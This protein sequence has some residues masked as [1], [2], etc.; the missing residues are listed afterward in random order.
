MVSKLPIIWKQTVKEQTIVVVV[1][2]V[3]VV[4]VVVVVFELAQMTLCAMSVGCLWFTD[5]TARHCAAR[6]HPSEPSQHV[7]SSSSQLG[8]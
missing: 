8:Y 2:V 5:T 7:A 1:V 6:T 3:V 4:D